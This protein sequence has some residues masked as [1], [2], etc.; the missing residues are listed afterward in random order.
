MKKSFML[1]FVLLSMSIFAGGLKD[2]KYWV[3][4]AE[5]KYGWKSFTAITVE[6]GEVVSAKHDKFNEEGKFAS[7]NDEYNTNMKAKS[8]SSPAEFSKELV[9]DYLA[10]KDID[11]VDTVAGATSNSNI[12]KAQVKFLLKKAEKGQTGKFIYSK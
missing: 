11:K 8:G 1:I 3:E 7:E 5:Y 2:G 12:F 10:K 4:D 9:E 6:K